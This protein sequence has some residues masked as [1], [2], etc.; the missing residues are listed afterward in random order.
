MAGGEKNE[1]GSVRRTE[2]LRTLEAITKLNAEGLPP[3]YTELRIELGWSFGKTYRAVQ[4]LIAC[5]RVKTGVSRRTIT[6]VPM[7]R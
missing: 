2:L 4:R 6:R 7:V 3:T 5:G 1:G